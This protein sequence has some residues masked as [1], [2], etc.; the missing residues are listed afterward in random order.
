MNC[1]KRDWLR[2]RWIYG[3]IQ[4]IFM[5]CDTMKILSE[6]G[7]DF[8]YFLFVPF[9]ISQA[10]AHDLYF[11]EQSL[12]VQN[13]WHDSCRGHRFIYQHLILNSSQR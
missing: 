11:D 3:H 12:K 5:C 4:C 6:S 9:Q 1:G 10:L 8:M 2:T 13:H 7:P